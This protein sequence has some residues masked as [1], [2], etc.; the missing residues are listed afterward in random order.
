MNVNV[1]KYQCKLI[2]NNIWAAKLLYLYQ[3][4]ILYGQFLPH[5]KFSVF[6]NSPL[7]AYE[8][9]NIISRSLVAKIVPKQR[10][11]PTYNI[12]KAR[13]QRTSSEKVVLILLVTFIFPSHG[14]KQIKWVVIAFT[15]LWQEQPKDNR[16]CRNHAPIISIQ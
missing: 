4:C 10:A 13:P 2:E 5:A 14:S 11:Y 1:I 6:E 9:W 7:G 16:F 8:I 12:S 3:S 15:S